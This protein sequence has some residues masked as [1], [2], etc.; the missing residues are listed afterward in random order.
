ML[1]DSPGV[2]RKMLAVTA[3]LQSVASLEDSPKSVG[4]LEA[5]RIGDTLLV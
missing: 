5:D 2:E 4:A 3:R 1:D